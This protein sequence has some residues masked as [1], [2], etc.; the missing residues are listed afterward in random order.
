MIVRKNK[1]KELVKIKC[2]K[3]GSEDTQYWMFNKGT[4]ITSNSKFK[5][6]KCCE[7]HT[8]KDCVLETIEV[9]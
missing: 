4:K 3:C 6:N 5:C 1:T 2:P 8:L 7:L 9:K